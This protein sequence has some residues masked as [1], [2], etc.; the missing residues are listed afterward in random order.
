MLRI[1]EFKIENL[2]SDCFTDNPAPVFSFSMIS[3][4][5]NVLLKKAILSV[6]NWMEVFERQTGL[7]Y[8]GPE[9]TPF[10]KYLAIL[11]ITDD[12]GE[13]AKAS[14]EFETGFMESKWKAAW[15]TDSSYQF[16][17]RKKSPRPMTFKKDFSIKG[18]IEQARIYSTA[19][20]IYE[21]EL[22][23]RKV[24]DEYFA[25][26]YTSYKNQLQYQMNDIT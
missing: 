18:E 8:E 24:G 22:N 3:S 6:N 16:K 7:V 21:L 19:L 9:L 23:G 14:L 2:S 10:T 12:H 20:G 13:T 26:G 5:K 4:E 15:I 11:E 17:E 1:N 25:P